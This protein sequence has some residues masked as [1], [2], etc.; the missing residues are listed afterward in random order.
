MT[1]GQRADGLDLL[2]VGGGVMGLF[3]AY[4]A[5][6]AGRR[7]A[8]L[9]RGRIGDPATASFGRTRSYRRDY[10]DPLYAR[11]ADE[12]IRLWDAFERDTASRAL[13]RCGCLNIASAGVTPDLADTYTQRSADTLA[14]LGMPPE[15]L[16]AAGLTGRYPYLRA[17]LGHLDQVAGLVDLGAVT[18][19]LLGAL[20]S[21]G[22][23]VH[24]KVETL[25]IAAEPEHALVTTDAGEF[26]ARSV[27]ITAGH[28]TNEVLDRLRGCRLQV[29]LTRDRPSEAKYFT[30]PAAVREQFRAEH[31]PV[32]A[33]LDTGIYVHPIVDGV[34]DKVKIGYY[35]P[36]DLP[37]ERSGL[38]DITAFVATCMPGLADAEAVNLAEVDDVDQCDY[39][40]VAD[41]DF[42][43]GP[44]PGFANVF[45]GVG[46][47]G[48][49]YKYA[50]WVGRVL[51]ALSSTGDP[52]Y[53]ITRFAPS[54]F[55]ASGKESRA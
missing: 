20:E 26:R 21:S 11:L 50:P 24:E 49:G 55:V 9:E 25:E 42:V 10:L 46:W 7:V 28:G 8:V 45:V 38:A 31:M 27:V 34:I 29:P 37:R 2:V 32:I 14:E 12:A 35:N 3:T 47:R 33:Y 18:A 1:A 19:A 54:R 36:P 5:S 39:D 44:V 30:P 16:D 52:G 22:V 23:A 13:V 17:D 6:A 43:L 48:T 40:L 15:E 4:C 53:D 51:A 41:D